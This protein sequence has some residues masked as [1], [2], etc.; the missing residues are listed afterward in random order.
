L[1]GHWLGIALPCHFYL[2]CNIV[3]PGDGPSTYGSSVESSRRCTAG[4]L[5]SSTSPPDPLPLA[6]QSSR[7]FARAAITRLRLRQAPFAHFQVSPGKGWPVALLFRPFLVCAQWKTL[8][9]LRFLPQIARYSPCCWG[10]QLQP[11]RWPQAT[12]D[13][14]SWP[15][16][17]LIC[18]IL[19]LLS[20]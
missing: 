6:N 10:P 20:M 14:R 2:Q 9:A 16:V 12:P 18:F 3:L 7:V 5:I 19:A 17:L 4:G 15:R 13:E 8:Y 1:A 11:C